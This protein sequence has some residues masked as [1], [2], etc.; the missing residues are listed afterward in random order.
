MVLPQVLFEVH[1]L[2]LLF[3]EPCLSRFAVIG[4]MVSLQIMGLLVSLLHYLL[5]IL[6]QLACCLL[7][8]PGLFK[9]LRSQLNFQ[10]DL[11]DFDLEDLEHWLLSTGLAY[12]RNTSQEAFLYLVLSQV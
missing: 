10:L 5:V 3:I 1:L 2:G 6:P 9:L 11:L 7:Y 8:G 4:K 12:Q